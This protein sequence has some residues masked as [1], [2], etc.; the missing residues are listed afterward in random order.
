MLPLQLLSL[1]SC[2]ERGLLPEGVCVSSITRFNIFL[3]KRRKE[4]SEESPW[5]IPLTRIRITR[6]WIAMYIPDRGIFRLLVDD[7]CGIQI[8]ALDLLDYLVSR[9]I[10]GS[11]L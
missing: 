1:V 6:E 8:R 2:R 5:E 9:L 10:R 4:S 7:L 11:L 3:E